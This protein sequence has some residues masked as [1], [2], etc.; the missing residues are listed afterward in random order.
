MTHQSIDPS[1][2]RVAGRSGQAK[3]SGLSLIEVLVTM[4]VLSV[5]LAGIAVMHINSMRYA[6]S[7][8]YTSIASS[9]AL[10]FEERLWREAREAGSDCVSDAQV[11]AIRQ[12]VQNR[13]GGNAPGDVV[14]PGLDITAVRQAGSTAADNW[15][16]VALRLEWTDGRF[17]RDE[18]FNYRTRVAC[19]DEPLGDDDDDDEDDD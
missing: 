17:D 11:Q 8:Y 10:D 3:A 12:Q 14:I 7:S 4:L 19:P 13:W 5:G 6:H 15:V 18:T 2:F 9:A 16:Q 1:R